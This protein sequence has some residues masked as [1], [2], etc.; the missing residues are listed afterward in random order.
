MRIVVVEDHALVR[1]GIKSILSAQADLKVVGDVGTVAGAV[2]MVQELAPDLVLMDFALPD[3]TGVDATRAILS[4]RPG[5]SIVFLT[6]LEDDPSLFAAIRSGAKGYLLKTTPLPQFIE[7]VRGVARGEAAI[8]AIMA[9]RILAEFAH[10]PRPR[11]E[12]DDPLKQLTA[13]EMEVLRALAN[14]ASN[15]DVA[16]QLV[17]SE[18]T[19]KSHVS[20]ILNKLHLKNRRQAARYAQHHLH[21][22]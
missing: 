22:G 9:S 4:A 8:T 14:G 13:R 2:T 15:R 20:N 5:T 3:G 16:T 10:L 7:Y 18:S 12:V 19:V 17:V 6:M 1:E 11:D 21:N